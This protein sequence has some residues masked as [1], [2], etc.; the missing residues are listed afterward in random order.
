MLITSLVLVS[1][2]GLALVFRFSNPVYALA[3]ETST[4]LNVF[5]TQ[6]SQTDQ[7][8][9]LTQ[10]VLLSDDEEILPENEET[11]RAKV[12]MARGLYRQ[13]VR[14]HL[15]NMDLFDL[16]R[17]DGK[18]LKDTAKAFREA[19]YTLSEA[20]Q[21]NARTIIEAF[22][23]ERGELRD[24]HGDAKA[25]LDSLRGQVSLENIDFVISSLQEVITILES[26]HEHFTNVLTLFA[27]AQSLL[28]AQ[29]V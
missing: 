21:E 3:A 7:S 12:I 10:T 5:E 11:Q 17:E 8:L 29:M 26:R 18:T 28:D 19:G 2:L 24:I 25:I 13:M 16:L 22:R 15:D 1:I 23:D 27:Q 14:L 9:S 20:D 6:S 4:S